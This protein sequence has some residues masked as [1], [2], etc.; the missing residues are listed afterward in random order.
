MKKVVFVFWL[1]VFCK[2]SGFAFVPV[3]EREITL[4]FQSEKMSSVLLR[5]QEQAGFVFSYQPSLLDGIAPVTLQLRKKTVRE[6]LTLLLP[7]SITFK[8]KNNYIILKQKQ[9]DKP[10]DKKE[11]SGYVIDRATDQ[12]VA[13]VTIYDQQSMQSVTTDQYGYYTIKVPVGNEKIN[14]NKENYKDT[15]VVLSAIGDSSFVNI[16]LKPDSLVFAGKDTSVPKRNRLNDFNIYTREVVGKFK[17]FI[18]TLNIRDTLKRPFQISLLPFVGTNHKLSGNVVNKLSINVVGGYAKGV[19][20]FEAGTLFNIDETNVQGVQL[21]GVFNIVGQSVKGTQCAGMFNIVGRSFDGFQAAGMMNIN[22][23]TMK[24][25]QLA[26]M[27]NISGRVEG[28][29]AAGLMNIA[30]TVKGVQLAGMANISDTLQGIAVS[31]LFNVSKYGK[32]SVQFSPLFNVSENGSTAAQITAFYNKASYVK[33]IQLGLIN[34]ADSAKGVPV[35]LLSFVKKGVHQ[36]E[37]STDELFSLN[38]S[39]R[40]GVPAFYNIL[41]A[42]IETGTSLWSAGYGVGSSLH[43][44]K[45]WY[46]EL[47]ATVSHLSKGGFYTAASDLYRFYVGFEYKF[48]KRFSVAAGPQLNIYV[49]DT[50]DTEFET[51]Y[52]Q[53]PPYFFGEETNAYG[54]NRKLWF[55]AKLAIRF[56]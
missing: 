52:S 4:N 53:I 16:S 50:Y 24:G 11:I 21:A 8:P 22:D 49:S 23:G 15:A 9:A 43:L 3:L 45:K 31:G 47:N 42:G 41:T 26:G 1:V 14:V 13:N 48:K 40:T 32:S 35:G 33:G 5:I 30:G 55:G 18:N 12:K 54:F 17:G 20:G 39:F 36:V 46:G 56:L 51:T 44:R 38:V 37:F 7:K 27:M 34:V 2:L 29:S 19:N 6:A 28:T 25:V 10:G